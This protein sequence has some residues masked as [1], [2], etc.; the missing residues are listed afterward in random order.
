MATG[1]LGE[2]PMGHVVNIQADYGKE[3]ERKSQDVLYNTKAEF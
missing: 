1:V 3:G 2:N